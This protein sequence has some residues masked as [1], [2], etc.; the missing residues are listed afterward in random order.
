MV[1]A[2]WK[3]RSA[4]VADINIAVNDSGTLR[5]LDAQSRLSDQ[6]SASR[7]VS[8]PCILGKVGGTTYLLP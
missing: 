2:Q 6:E 4:L 5:F 3:K 7:F 1:I 8:V